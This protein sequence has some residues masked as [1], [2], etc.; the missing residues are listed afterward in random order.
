M[1]LFQ[2][3]ASGD[4]SSLERTDFEQNEISQN[5]GSLELI[6]RDQVREEVKYIC[7]Y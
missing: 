3:R 7:N 5:D 2:P 4:P 1:N 6:E